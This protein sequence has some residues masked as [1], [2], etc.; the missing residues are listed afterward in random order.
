MSKLN[1][2]STAWDWLAVEDWAVGIWYERYDRIW[3]PDAKTGEGFTCLMPHLSSAATGYVPTKGES[4]QFWHYEADLI[5]PPLPGV[6][7][8][9]EN[10]EDIRK[11][12]WIMEHLT[13]GKYP[14]DYDTD[15]VFE[16]LPSEPPGDKDWSDIC[17]YVGELWV[18]WKGEYWVNWVDITY[19]YANAM[20]LGSN[21]PPED[22]HPSHNNEWF[23]S[24]AFW[25]IA[26]DPNRFHHWDSNSPRFYCSSGQRG[27]KGGENPFRQWQ[28]IDSANRHYPKQTDPAEIERPV[29]YTD[30]GRDTLQ[31]KNKRALSRYHITQPD[32]LGAIYSAWNYYWDEEALTIVRHHH[33]LKGEDS[34]QGNQYAHYY[35]DIL[36][37]NTWNALTEARP[38]YKGG[39]SYPDNAQ[40][41]WDEKFC[42][43]LQN[44]IERICSKG[45]W[46][47]PT[48]DGSSTDNNTDQQQAFQDNWLARADP[49]G[50]TYPNGWNP[51]EYGLQPW[52]AKMDS[53]FWGCNESAF[54][55]IL[56]LL[57][58]Y[59]W[60][61][62]T[63]YPHTSWKIVYW[64]FAE[65]YESFQS[66]EAAFAKYPLPLGT[67]RRT[68]KYSFLRRYIPGRRFQYMRDGDYFTPEGQEW[69]T[70]AGAG[71]TWPGLY[72]NEMPNFNLSQDEID[73]LASRHS[74][75]QEGWKSRYV[76]EE[77]VW[78]SYPEYEIQAA[79]VVEMR[80]VLEQLL[81][82]TS[83]IGPEMMVSTMSCT[84]VTQ[85]EAI[86]RILAY[87]WLS[88]EW[89]QYVALD[90]G[91]GTYEDFNAGEKVLFKGWGVGDDAET[92]YPFECLITGSNVGDLHANA[93]TS[94]A[95]W[96][97]LA[98]TT[99]YPTLSHV[100][101]YETGDID[102][103]FGVGRFGMDGWESSWT[104]FAIRFV[105]Y[106]A[107]VE[108]AWAKIQ[109]CQRD[110]RL[111]N[112]HWHV[113]GNN[114]WSGQLVDEDNYPLDPSTWEWNYR[115][116]YGDVSAL[117][118]YQPPSNPDLDNVIAVWNTIIDWGSTLSRSNL[119][120]SGTA[121]ELGFKLDL[122]L[123][124]DSVWELDY[125]NH[126]DAAVDILEI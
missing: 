19:A 15:F 2:E 105:G 119:Q 100:M 51:V 21:R 109:Y 11:R 47:W 73:S 81:Y 97:Y 35:G 122:N 25:V 125:T 48:W 113:W 45:N 72:V 49:T 14:L 16:S 34:L 93:E 33:I 96:K 5:K 123:I 80:N 101:G 94:N 28:Y 13:A 84:G 68:W 106:P 74:P 8:H 69:P 58:E 50:E 1:W 70:T 9:H 121:F 107:W 126:I 52:Y 36:P 12:L 62:D 57:G 3:F 40:W 78:D 6:E 53:E 41:S 55:L 98:N 66:W 99:D 38:R 91:V 116:F 88:E 85:Q 108:L 31:T 63:T 115:L 43:G 17:Y 77:L 111:E 7:I 82:Y 56:W 67:W 4:N 95:N 112:N 92:Y 30:T 32:T 103:G 104:C 46:I 124:P 76:D 120:L 110:F 86:D 71:Y 10:F 118:K 39:T 75:V 79:M 20:R 102:A 29:H 54:E 117:G 42:D 83:D 90:K 22:I 65:V 114:D 87:R 61:F 24:N 44:R 26:P 23:L 60:Y 59:D 27:T 37:G 18:I 64:T 89:S